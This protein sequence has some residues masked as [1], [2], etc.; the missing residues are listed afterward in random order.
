MTN[1]QTPKVRLLQFGSIVQATVIKILIHAFREVVTSAVS[2]QDI[3]SSLTLVG[4]PYVDSNLVD[5]CFNVFR[6]TLFIALH[7]YIQLYAFQCYTCSLV[8][9][10]LIPCDFSYVVLRSGY[11]L[12]RLLFT[13]CLF[14]AFNRVFPQLKITQYFN[15]VRDSS[16]AFSSQLLGLILQT[17]LADFHQ[18]KCWRSKL[19]KGVIL[20][21]LSKTLIKNKIKLRCSRLKLKHYKESSSH[22]QE[23]AEPKLKAK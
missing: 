16:D 5:R 14:V 15:S 9:L 22:E 20:Y 1:Q 3:Q 2:T 17:L 6:L 23:P 7:G 19:F 8:H 21:K 12:I 10:I 11:L 4:H 18:N 13:F